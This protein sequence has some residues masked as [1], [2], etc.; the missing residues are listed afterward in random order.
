[1]RLL[2][3]HFL[4]QILF[5]PAMKKLPTAPKLVIDTFFPKHF[6]QISLKGSCSWK[7]SNEHF[8][9]FTGRFN[10]KKFFSPINSDNFHF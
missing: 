6:T 3:I 1:M 10:H 4:V 9:V 7:F 8:V 2:I 5:P